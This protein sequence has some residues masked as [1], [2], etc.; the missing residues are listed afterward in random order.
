MFALVS[1]DALLWLGAM[2]NAEMSGDSCVVMKFVVRVYS[3]WAKRVAVIG[4]SELVELVE[5][6]F[7][8]KAEAW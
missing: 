1:M 5:A 2:I 7:A 3:I 6:T 4:C 8:G